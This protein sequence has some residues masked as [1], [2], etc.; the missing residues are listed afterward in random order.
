MDRNDTGKFAIPSCRP[1]TALEFFG[2]ET[3]ERGRFQGFHVRLIDENLD[4][5]VHVYADYSPD[6][7]SFFADLAV[8]WRD[9]AN[10]REW[11]S[12]EGE[13][14]LSAT[15]D[16]RGHIALSVVLCNGTPCRWSAEAVIHTE[17]GLLDRIAADCREFVG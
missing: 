9:W 1:P 15:H 6:L 14:R 3:D 8:N 11:V 5:C 4:A 2:V 13:L 12:Q 7:A 16:G 17:A 10:A